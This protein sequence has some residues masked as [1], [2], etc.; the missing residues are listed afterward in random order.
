ME[1]PLRTIVFQRREE[2]TPREK[3]DCKT[4]FDGPPFCFTHPSTPYIPAKIHYVHC[5]F[6]NENAC[7]VTADGKCVYVTR[8]QL[9]VPSCAIF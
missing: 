8:D 9:L 5:I 3:C 2:P 4:V 6:D 7:F 1:A